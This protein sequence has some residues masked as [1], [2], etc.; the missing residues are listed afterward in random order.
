MSATI[1]PSAGNRRAIGYANLR[2]NAA[3]KP[4]VS[5]NPA[6][7][8]KKLV[9]IAE[10]CREH[11]PRAVQVVV[12]LLDDAD[13]RVRMAAAKELLDRGYGKPT[14]T[15][16]GADAATTLTFLHLVAARAASEMQAQRIIEGAAT[17]VDTDTE[18]SAPPDLMAPALE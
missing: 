7:R 1:E 2:P 3:W 10:L 5:G 4:G 15:I 6:G 11:G 18:T 14:Q 12:S 8:P 13:S 9:D 16:E 17:T